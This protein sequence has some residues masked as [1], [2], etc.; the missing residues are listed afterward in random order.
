MAATFPDTEKY[1][2]AWKQVN[3]TWLIFADISNSNRA[4]PMQSGAGK[5]R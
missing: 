1:V 4:M 3:G 2:T 5:R